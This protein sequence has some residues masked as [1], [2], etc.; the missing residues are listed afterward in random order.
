MVTARLYIEGGGEDKVAS[1]FGPG[2]RPPV[3]S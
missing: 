3:P 2:S 1:E